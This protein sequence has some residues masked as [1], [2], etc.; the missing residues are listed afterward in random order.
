MRC[1]TVLGPSQTGKST[2]VEKLGSLEGTPRK[3]NSPYGLNLTEFIFGNEAWCALDAPGPNEALAHAQ[4][5]LLASDACILCVS[6]APEE[7]VLAAPYLRIVEASGTP[8]ILFV[9]RMDEPRGRLRDVIAALQD[10][11][12]HT[13]LLRQIPI[14][15]GDRIIGSC[16]LISERAWRYREGQPSALIAIPESTAEREHEARTELLE[17]LSEFDDWLLEELIEDR[18]PSS[19][20]LYAISSRVLRENRIIPVLI[21][22]ASHGNGMMRLMKAL[23]HEAPPVGI[24]R[25][26]LAHAG[27]VDEGKLA[28]VSF[29]AYHRQN[30]GKTVLVRALG[31]GLRQGASLGGSSLGAVQSLANGRSNSPVLPAPGDVFATVKSD[32]LP[33]PSLLTSGAVVA[34]PEW[35]EPP[36]PMLERILVPASERDENKLSETLAKLSETDRGLKVL[37]EEGTGAQLVRAQG[38]VHLRDLCRTL[39]DVFHISVTDRTPS[40]TYRETIAKP[41]EVHYRHRKQTGGAGQFA[42]VKLSIHPNERGQGFTFGETV[43]GGAVPRNYFPAVEAGAREAMEKGPLGFEVI[44]VGV[45]LLDGQHH[46]VD[47][48]EH[49]FRTASKMGVRQAFSEGSTVLMQPIFRT[50]FHIPSA[51]SGSL[52]QIVAALNGQV[53]GFDRDEAAK[54][55]DI[56]RALV[57]GGALE[58]LARSLRSATQGIGYFS[59][60][61]DHFEELY[62]KEADAIVKARE[63]SGTAH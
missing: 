28:A 23:R 7:A 54:G 50:E 60:T 57:P 48:S 30:V 62:G 49:A 29:H 25:Q 8:C 2:V 3:S 9:N 42:D 56:F 59:K 51:Y 33:V 40:P 35:T 19:D 58:D 37:Q 55:W 41:S 1:F 38:P 44:D 13:L 39:A 14:R 6:P 47:S 45:T 15:E 20:A 12:S 10:Y 4:Q 32:H 36:T 31:E 21:G 46:S 27:T 63:K 53:L 18:E 34:P 43:K 22:A 11:A 24:L 17:Y 52:V 16:D 26:R 5:A 61:F